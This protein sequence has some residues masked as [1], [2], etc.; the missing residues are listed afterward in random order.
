MIDPAV[1]AA[2]VGE[3]G[4]AAGPV[5]IFEEGD[6]LLGSVAGYDFALEP[7]SDSLFVLRSDAERLD[8]LTLEF[9]PANPRA[10]DW[11]AGDDRLALMGQWFAF[12]SE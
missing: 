10:Q 8:G 9:L 11:L 4:S 12:R 1:R 5:R 2:L 3:Y 7:M 6:R